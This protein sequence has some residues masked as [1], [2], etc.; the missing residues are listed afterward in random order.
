MDQSRS[1]TR[2]AEL[3]SEHHKTLARRY[4]EELWSRGDLA[5]ADEILSP[6]FHFHGPG[7][8]IHGA[9]SFKQFVAMFRTSFPD[10]TFSDQEY[11]AEGDRVASYFTMSGTQHSTFQGIPPT[12]YRV[13]VPGM[14]VFHM[15]G[16][17]ISDIRISMDTLGMLQQLGVLPEPGDD[18]PAPIR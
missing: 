2:G 11:I 7:V 15:T 12:G 16:G 18:I 1:Q 3:M 14:H 17:K 9:E 6:D 10:L 13:T 4:F 8:S 5:V